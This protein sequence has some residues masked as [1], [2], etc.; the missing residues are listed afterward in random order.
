MNDYAKKMSLA[1]EK[2]LE[3]KKER[4]INKAQIVLQFASGES[5]ENTDTALYLGSVS[6]PQDC[7]FKRAVVTSSFEVKESY[8]ELTLTQL[9]FTA[10]A[11]IPVHLFSSFTTEHINLPQMPADTV[12]SD[13]FISPKGIELAGKRPTVNLN[14]TFE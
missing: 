1:F 13:R 2:Q 12:L 3:E 6:L 9:Y 10:T 4:S 11:K 14:L 7:T 8:V 5:V